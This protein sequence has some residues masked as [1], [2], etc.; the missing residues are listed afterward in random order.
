MVASIS[1]MIRETDKITAEN[2]SFYDLGSYLYRAFPVIMELRTSSTAD[3]PELLLNLSS[4]IDLAKD[5]VKSFTGG[6]SIRDEDDRRIIIQR[7]ESVARNIGNCL[8]SIPSSAF[9]NSKCA[10]IAA[11]SISRDMIKARFNFDDIITKSEDEKEVSSSDTDIP[12][13]RLVDFSSFDNSIAKSDEKEVSRFDTDIP[14]PRLV[15][16]ITGMHYSSREGESSFSGRLLEPP[17][18]SFFCP[19]TRKIM[20]DPVT[21]ETGLTFERAAIEEWLQ[22][23]EN[24]NSPAV[25]PVTGKILDNRVMN[26]NLALGT[27]IE[28]WKLRNEATRIRLA[29]R[30]LSKSDSESVVLEAMGDLQS[31]CWRRENKVAMCNSGVVPLLAE[32][33]EQ[34][35]R[36][37]RF[38]AM[39]TLRLLV[40][41][42]EE[43][44][45]TSRE[46]IAYDQI[47][48]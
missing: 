8:G 1:Q 45:V 19:L 35:N 24:L 15:D 2:S 32:F 31:L 5:L 29:S 17:Y 36:K 33:M 43:G 38:E 23:F 22:R 7:L 10:A 27:M 44:Q 18:E 48:I 4:N 41:D 40:E 21:I 13:P 25:C 20:E 30:Y 46:I 14:G 28:E 37:I 6:R 47:Y 42:D 9:K 11:K 12:G 39:E 3:L 34:N 26:K 16:F